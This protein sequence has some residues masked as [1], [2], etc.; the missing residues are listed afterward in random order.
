MKTTFIYA[1]IDPRDN[2]I[3]YIG[4]A[5]N[6]I[7]RLGGHFLEKAK[8]K[9]NNWLKS[10]KKENL[11]P[12][13]FILDE[14]PKEEWSFWER[15]YISLYKSWGFELKNGTDGGEGT[16]N[17]SK[18]T[19]LKMSLAKKDKPGARR[20]FKATEETKLKNRL[21]ALG[22][23]DSEETK[24]K[25]AAVRKDKTFVELF[26][27]EKT[28]EIKQNNK[29]AAKK[30][31]Q[32]FKKGQV[33]WNK[34]KNHSLESITKMSFTHKKNMTKEKKKKISDKVS[35]TIRIKK[36]KGFQF[37]HARKIQQIALDGT[38]LKKFDSAKSAEA[39]FGNKK[40]DNIGAC[41]RGTRKTAY[42][43]KWKFI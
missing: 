7:N 2:K 13:L 19:R 3:K 36:E 31:K 17:P 24:K 16:F 40:K 43:Y 9:K 23:K 12:E 38:I 21:A 6:P 15:Y 39:F 26:G 32:T 28:N 33:A 11:K 5:D 1:L 22:R 41:A 42:G 30:R 37:K 29:S 14:I 27:K 8:T 35:E 20:G 34:D 10:L 25:K 4:K 18:E